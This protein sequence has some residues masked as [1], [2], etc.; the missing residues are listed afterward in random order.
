[1]SSLQG[2]DGNEYD[3]VC[4]LT[5][6]ASSCYGRVAYCISIIRSFAGSSIDIDF[7]EIPIHASCIC[8]HYLAALDLR[9]SALALL[10]DLCFSTVTFLTALGS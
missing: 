8:W 3:G 4:Y 2:S 5:A 10:A 1:M 6:T 7:I 9:D